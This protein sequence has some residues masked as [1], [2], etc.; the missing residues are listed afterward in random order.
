MQEESQLRYKKWHTAINTFCCLYKTK[1]EVFTKNQCP[2]SLVNFIIS[3]ET[4]QKTFLFLGRMGGRH[5]ITFF[6]LLFKTIF[7]SSVPPPTPSGPP[8]ISGHGQLWRGDVMS[9]RGEVGLVGAEAQGEGR[10]SG[11][12]VV[13]MSAVLGGGPRGERPRDG[14]LMRSPLLATPC[15]GALPE[16]ASPSPAGGPTWRPCGPAGSPRSAPSC[17]A[18][19]PRP[20]G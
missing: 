3:L 18:V 12:V 6:I 17:S 1:K 14:V 16:R 19:S 2:L 9:G 15:S 11:V 7:A 5:Y 13:V 8:I 20:C 10:G 4:E